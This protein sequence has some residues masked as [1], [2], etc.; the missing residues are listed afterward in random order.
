[1]MAASTGRISA[2]VMVTSAA[3]S[4]V[5]QMSSSV[6]LLAHGHVF[7]HVAAGLAQKPHR[8]SIDL[9]YGERL[10]EIDCF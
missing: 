6:W 7:R 9:L 8:G 10:S 5:R 1:M 3:M 2:A 4:G